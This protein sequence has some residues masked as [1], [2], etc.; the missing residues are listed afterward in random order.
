MRMDSVHYRIQLPDY[1]ELE[2]VYA[3]NYVFF[4]VQG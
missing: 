3:K 4:D 2:A 1:F